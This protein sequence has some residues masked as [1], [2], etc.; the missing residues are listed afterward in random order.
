MFEQVSRND[1]GAFLNTCNY[2]QNGINV[3]N[4]IDWDY[5]FQ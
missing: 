4:T 2:S 3:G 5:D 1:N